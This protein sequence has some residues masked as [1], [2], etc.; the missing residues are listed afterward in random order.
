VVDVVLAQNTNGCGSLVGT[1]VTLL[2]PLAQPV[3]VGQKAIC[4]LDSIIPINPQPF[5]PPDCNQTYPT[6]SEFVMYVLQASFRPV[7]ILTDID[8]VECPVSET[9]AVDCYEFLGG[10][11]IYCNGI[12]DE[13]MEYN[14]CWKSRQFYFESAW[15]KECV[16]VGECNSSGTGAGDPPVDACNGEYQ[17]I[18]CEFQFGTGCPL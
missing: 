11:Q 3:C 18:E 13:W 6:D 8:L 2:N 5:N 14:L 10:D 17:G 4:Y 7:C 12:E 16:S 15:S 9:R 1:K